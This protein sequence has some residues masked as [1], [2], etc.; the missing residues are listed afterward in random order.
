MRL[1]TAMVVTL[2][3][4]ILQKKNKDMFAWEKKE[5]FS[6]LITYKANGQ[7]QMPKTHTLRNADSSELWPNSG[8][9]AVELC[10]VISGCI[11]SPG[12]LDPSHMAAQRN[13]IIWTQVT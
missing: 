13:K 7:P 5:K 6:L 3:E 2:F 4:A 8:L 9:C 11:C 1:I 10:A 12:C